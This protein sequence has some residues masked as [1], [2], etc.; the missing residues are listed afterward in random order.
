[1]RILKINE[2]LKPTFDNEVKKGDKIHI[3]KMNGEPQYT[4]KEGI[5]EYID[6]IGQIHGTWGGCALI[7]GTDEYT[8]VEKA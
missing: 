5:V 1:M 6:D 3:I 7:P 8:I 4:N 2:F